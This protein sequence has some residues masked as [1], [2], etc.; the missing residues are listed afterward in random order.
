MKKIVTLLICV[1][2]V[3]ALVVP[4]FADDGE[5]SFTLVADKTTAAKGETITFT[6]IANNVKQ[7][8]GLG[9]IPQLDTDVF[10]LTG[11]TGNVPGAMLSGFDVQKGIYAIAA[12]PI[13]VSGEIGTFTVE[14]ISDCGSG[15]ITAIA[16]LD[17]TQVPAGRITQ[18]SVTIAG[19]HS[20]GA[21]TPNGENH[22][23]TC[24]KCGAEETGEH[25][26]VKGEVTQQPNCT[27]EGKQNAACSECGL[28][29]SI[30]IP[31]NGEHSWNDGEIT[32]VPG[33]ETEGVKTYTCIHNAAH[34]Y[35]EAIAPIGHK[36]E[37]AVTAPSCTEKGYTTHTCSACS[38]SYMDT[39]VE[40]TGHDMGEWYAVTP[41][42]CEA[43]G[44]D[45]R[46]CAKCDYFETKTTKALGHDY[47][48]EVTTPATCKDE[49]VLTYTCQNDPS[50][51]YTESIPKTNTHTPSNE[52]V[53]IKAPTCTETGISSG[54]CAVCGV[55]M[56]EF[57]TD[58]LG[59]DMGE[60][61]VK[62]D[63]TC[64]ADG[65]MRSDCSRCDHF[66]SK[67]I[68]KKEHTYV[69]VVTAPT[70]T[71][72]GFVTH[73]CSVCGNS[74]E[75]PGD[76]ALGHEFGE[77]KQTK[78]PTCTE[79][80]EETA[81]CIRCDATDTR[82]IDANG[83]KYEGT[84][85]EPTCTEPGKES[86]KCSVCGDEVNEKEI[87]ALGHDFG[88]Y[89][90]TKA[91]TCTEKGE[92]TA[93]CSRCDATDV[94]E[95]PALGHTFGDWIK[96]DDVNHKHVCH[97]G[98][99]EVVAHN[100]DTG[101]VTL[102]PTHTST[103]IKTYECKDCHATREEE[104]AKNPEHDF[105]EKAE[106]IVD[107]EGNVD[108]KYH[109]GICACG[110]RHKEKHSYDILGD[111]IKEPTATTKG[112]RE[113]FCACG[114]KSIAKINADGTLDDEPGMGDITGQIVMSGIAAFGVLAAAAYVFNHKR[115]A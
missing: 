20:F 65:E 11:G 59:H 98:H 70:C 30:S 17:G 71:L 76:K 115:I 52:T 96:V 46:D 100:W 60:W 48:S 36:Y 19:E 32:T 81:K 50:H 66:D 37:A 68:D 18:V 41:A 58:A 4:A 95:I 21:W 106:Q 10:K 39:Y 80:G 82:E 56:N 86:G 51:T 6:V 25:N 9:V 61:Y 1:L 104:I 57:K 14:V 113:V 42:T 7:I 55:N 15:S 16:S 47:K 67:V 26:M 2:L 107:E 91:P 24:P 35:T 97:C 12:A 79:K 43:T 3:A 49:G 114:H 74:Y 110:E 102:E 69:S 111:I 33:C 62:T 94:K 77:Y 64:T 101:M 44:T 99:E 75:T 78:A 54:K 38:D 89:K 83:H 72:N 45:R 90:Q 8:K 23:R 73:T 28:S 105:T 87:P 63:S 93:E 84:R 13:D 5:I 29:T 31:T 34:T 27:T 109:T 40:P 92:E 88:E 112:E 103:G 22:I 108:D 53:E 85:V